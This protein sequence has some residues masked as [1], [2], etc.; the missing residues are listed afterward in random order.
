MWRIRAP[1]HRHFDRQ[2]CSGVNDPFVLHAPEQE[3]VMATDR[4]PARTAGR[5]TSEGSMVSKRAPAGTGTK[6]RQGKR[7]SSLVA[8]T[9]AAPRNA[10]LHAAALRQAAD[11][12]LL[13]TEI[14]RVTAR[15]PKGL[16]ERAKERTGIAST[17][18]LLVFALA[19]AAF[20]DGFADA[21]AAAR[22]RIDP[23]L[24]IGF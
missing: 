1:I 5:K 15:L 4:N 24:D 3:A 2:G 10:A 13:S 14:R 9:E 18:D 6:P 20:E 8:V 22:G 23:D 17:T 12:G 19:N 11:L 21:F 16:L 7:R